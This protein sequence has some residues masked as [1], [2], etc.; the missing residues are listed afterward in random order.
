MGIQQF[1]R[2]HFAIHDAHPGECSACDRIRAALTTEAPAPVTH[3]RQVKAKIAK[4]ND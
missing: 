1:E 4:H 3:Q 2:N